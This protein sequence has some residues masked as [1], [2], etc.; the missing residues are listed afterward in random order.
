VEEA[1]RK[2]IFHKVDYRGDRAALWEGPVFY[3]LPFDAKQDFCSVV[4][5]YVLTESRSRAADV[6]LRDVTSGKTVRAY[7]FTGLEMK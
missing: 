7:D 2:R 1:I 6:T 4:W 3:D 5:A